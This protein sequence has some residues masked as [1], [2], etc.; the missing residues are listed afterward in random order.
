MSETD[1]TKEE[2]GWLK[3]LLGLLVAVDV[4]LVAWIVGHFNTASHSLLLVAVILAFLFACVI[5]AINYYA[6]WAIKKLGEL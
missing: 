1:K 2:I 4:P 5:I 3:L 6:Y